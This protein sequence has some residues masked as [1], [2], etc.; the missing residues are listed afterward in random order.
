MTVTAFYVGL[1]KDSWCYKYFWVSSD[2]FIWVISLKV[3][4]VGFSRAAKNWYKLQEISVLMKGFYRLSLVLMAI[5][6]YSLFVERI[7]VIVTVVRGKLGKVLARFYL[8]ESHYRGLTDLQT[9][10]NWCGGDWNSQLLN[11]REHG[12]D[13]DPGDPL[14]QHDPHEHGSSGR[15]EHWEKSHFNSR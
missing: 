2:M 15:C 13:L 12:K 14:P 5:I 7:V 4:K 10:Y 3:T 8:E 11:Y 6:L 1:L 9:W